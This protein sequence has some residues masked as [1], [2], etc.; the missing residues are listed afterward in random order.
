MEYEALSGAPL[1]PGIKATS[2]LETLPVD[3][4]EQ[5]QT[6]AGLEQSY[7][8]LRDY[9]LNQVGR[10][11]KLA[12]PGPKQDTAPMD[13]GAVYEPAQYEDEP[14]YDQEWG[15]DAAASDELFYYGKG[16]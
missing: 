2:F 14:V 15:S 8:A 12:N 9:A 16:G 11:I 6:Q 7:T 1:D 3:L 5:A 4:K 10:K 13:I